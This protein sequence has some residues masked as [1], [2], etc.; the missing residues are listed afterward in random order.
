MDEAKL[1]AY[2]QLLT[3]AK[4]IGEEL[5]DGVLHLTKQ[6]LSPEEMAAVQARWDDNAARSARNA[7]LSPEV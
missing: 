5:Y 4:F 2:L 3:T 7:G 1:Q 6:R